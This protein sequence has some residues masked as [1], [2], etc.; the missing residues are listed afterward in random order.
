MGSYI[1]ALKK[2]D[3]QA[4][5]ININNKTWSKLRSTDI[6][7][8]LSGTQEKIFSLNSKSNCGSKKE[9]LSVISFSQFWGKGKF[10]ESKIICGD[11]SKK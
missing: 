2:V 7:K 1:G 11:F 5:M 8:F 3:G 4:G 6:Q 9:L 10:L